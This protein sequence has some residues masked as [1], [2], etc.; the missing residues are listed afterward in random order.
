[1]IRAWWETR[2]RARAT[3]ARDREHE[4]VQLVLKPLQAGRLA[5]QHSLRRSRS[6]GPPATRRTTRTSGPRLEAAGTGQGGRRPGGQGARGRRSGFVSRPTTAC[7]SP[8]PPPP[9]QDQ[10]KNTEYRAWPRSRGTP[11]PRAAEPPGPGPGDGLHTGSDGALKNNKDN[12]GLDLGG[13]FS[14]RYG[15]P[16]SPSRRTSRLASG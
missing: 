11:W 15:A 1:M 2:R 14:L 10:Q 5:S 9:A 8:D 16:D 12:P 3:R 4:S 7:A 6:T 13:Y